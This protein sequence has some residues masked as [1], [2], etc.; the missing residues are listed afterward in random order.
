MALQRIDIRSVL[1]EAFDKHRQGRLGEAQTL[2]R[3][4]LRHDRNNFDALQLLGLCLYQANDPRAALECLDAA[5]AINRKVPAVFSH[6]GIVLRAL[7]RNADAVA[8]FDAALALK[9]DFADAHYN[10]ANALQSLGR[11]EEARKHFEAAVRLNPGKPEFLN[12]LAGVLSELN[13]HAAALDC[14]VKLVQLHPGNAQAALNLGLT[15]H[16]LGRYEEAVA[17]YTRVIGVNPV[18]AEAYSR[19][20]DALRELGNLTE[21]LSDCDMALGLNPALAEA[22]C[23]R[24]NVLKQMTQ[25]EE[26]LASYDKAL[27]LK[28]DYAEAFSNRGL[29]LKEL[30]RL[31]EALA[32]LDEALRLKPDY[33]EAHANRGNVLSD[34][35]RLDDAIAS[36]DAA[37]G[38]RPE[39]A[40]AHFNKANALAKLRR[41][42][43]AHASYDKAIGLRPDYAEACLNKALLFMRE[44]D[45]PNGFRVYMRRWT[46][47]DRA[48][49]LPVTG[50][51]AWD[52]S[53]TAGRLLLWNEQGIGDEVFYASML[54]LVSRDLSVTLLAD[55]RL[56]AIYERSFPGIALLDHALRNQSAETEF[57]VQA[58]LGDLGHLLG[59]SAE[60]I[61]QRSYP[62]LQANPV[63]RQQLVGENAFLRGKPVCGVAWRSVNRNFGD[64]KSIRLADLSPLLTAPDLTFV[65]L[66]YGNVSEEIESVADAIGTPV[67]VAA[68]LDVFQDIDGLLALIDACDIVLTTSNVTAHL[69]GAIGKKAAVLLP[70]GKG[71]LWYWH[72]E[73]QSTWYPSLRLFA[74]GEASDWSDPIRRASDWVRENAASSA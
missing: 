38:L 59:M 24:G 29:A 67:H 63:R 12:N 52:G 16:R 32:S 70:T 58:A 72:D 3:T 46:A 39:H 50:V 71:R 69:A 36:Y 54:S 37:I 18:L 62:F 64:E 2:Y 35:D 14:Y 5:L 33:A 20:G 44:Q 26:A 43:E 25:F 8:D 47:K 21:A 31:D 49:K 55:R 42:A 11:R 9:P 66:Q 10:K 15:L 19:R 34:L 57:D 65:N 68:N 6:R 13:Q 4:V 41:L 22:H 27:G 23:S 1:G 40:E 53:P 56:H 51:P 48:A 45:Y 17:T 74:Q 7:G 30:K 73:P 61:R 60:R 28:P